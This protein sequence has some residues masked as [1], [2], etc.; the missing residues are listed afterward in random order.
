MLKKPRI[1]KLS[2]LLKTQPKHNKNNEK[3]NPGW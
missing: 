3:Q 1:Y 2:T